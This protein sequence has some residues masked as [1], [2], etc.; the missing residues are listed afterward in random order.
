MANKNKDEDPEEE[1]KNQFDDD[2]DFGLPDLEYEELEDDDDT[3]EES[4]D[5]EPAAEAP[6]AD[7]W[8]KELEEQPEEETKVDDTN[9]SSEDLFYQ[10]ESF[11]EFEQPASESGSDQPVFDTDTGAGT[12]PPTYTAQ[13]DTGDSSRGKFARVV[14]IGTLLF[15]VIAIVFW[16]VNDGAPEPKEP[17]AE[18]EPPTEVIPVDTMPVVEEPVVEPEPVE[19]QANRRTPGEITVLEQQTG[20]SY[21]VIGSFFDGDLAQDYAKK[22]S[23]EGKS[24]LIIPPFKNYR[25][26]RV[27]IA[28]FESFK[29]AQASVETYKQ[30]YGDSVWSLRY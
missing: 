26:H 1:K 5:P 10:E 20:K 2:E 11:D 18:I 3:S 13:Y 12:P 8:E 17:I 6:E 27:A 24:P 22:L 7:E 15:A 4:S 14:V 25:F 28:E 30:E 16:L 23:A 29:A 19:S 21:I 9:E